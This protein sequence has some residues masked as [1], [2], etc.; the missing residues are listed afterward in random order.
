MYSSFS[1]LPAVIDIRRIKGLYLVARLTRDAIP[2][3]WKWHVHGF[4]NDSAAVIKKTAMHRRQLEC[5]GCITSSWKSQPSQRIRDWLR[6]SENRAKESTSN[7]KRKRKPKH[8]LG[9]VYTIYALFH[10]YRTF[11]LSGC[12]VEYHCN[13]DTT[14][15]HNLQRCENITWFRII[16]HELSWTRD[17]S[18]AWLHSVIRLYRRSRTDNSWTGFLSQRSQCFFAKHTIRIHQSL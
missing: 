15:W 5:G 16:T 7:T 12:W 18:E 3:A 1:S 4:F 14:D 10:I 17:T 13:F 8:S 11:T 6:A 9:Y 2:L